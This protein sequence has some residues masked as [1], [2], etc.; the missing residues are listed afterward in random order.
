LSAFNEDINPTVKA[1][2]LPIPLL[3]GKSPT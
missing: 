3:A 1:E 2:E